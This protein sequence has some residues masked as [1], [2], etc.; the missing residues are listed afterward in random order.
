MMTLSVTQPMPTTRPLTLTDKL[1]LLREQG[2]RTEV[3]KTYAA[4]AK[5]TG[6]SPEAVRRVFTGLNPDPGVKT[7]AAIAAYFG[8]NLGYF[9]CQNRAESLLF[10]QRLSQTNCV[11]HRL[12]GL[13]LTGQMAIYGL[14][15]YLYEAQAAQKSGKSLPAMSEMGWLSLY[16]NSS[17]RQIGMLDFEQ[18][19]LKNTQPKKIMP[20][21]KS[22]PPPPF[23]LANKVD[24]LFEYGKNSGLDVTYRAIEKATGDVDDAALAK[25]RQGGIKNPGYKTLSSIANYF[26][27][28]LDYF[29]C[30]TR[31]ECL[32]YLDGITQTEIL[33]GLALRAEGLSAKG[34]EAVQKMIDYAR[35]AEGLPP[36]APAEAPAE[37]R[38]PK[39]A[40]EK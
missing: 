8:A 3:G 4:I 24:L 36:T 26:G 20:P 33:Q 16:Y 40:K 25:I 39:K 6:L 34:L 29:D 2:S 9:D 35:I 32:A 21:K 30:A 14:V 19:R 11:I 27:V 22:S 37:P 31:E 17:M 28:R 15:M 13:S 5:G 23:T 1:T 12:A 38:S 18:P 7:L 10:F